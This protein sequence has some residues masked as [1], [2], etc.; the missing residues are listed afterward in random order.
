MRVTVLLVSAIAA[1]ACHRPLPAETGG[2]GQGSVTGHG[3]SPIP[4]AAGVGGS[5]DAAPPGLAG[6]G[7]GG[8]PGGMGDLGG[9][10]GGSGG[11]GGNAS[12]GSGDAVDGGIC[13][14]PDAAGIPCNCFC[15]GSVIYCSQSSRACSIGDGGPG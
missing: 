14:L 8:A 7:G 3:G 4:V 11:T 6:A 12:G 13:N 2:P 15:R 1:A 10:G 5:A 9:T